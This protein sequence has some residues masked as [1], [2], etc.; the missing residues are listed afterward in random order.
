MNME[1][2]IQGNSRAGGQDTHA[3]LA[4]GILWG[5]LGGLAG[6]LLMDLL[7]MGILVLAGLPALTCFAI[8]GDTVARFFSLLGSAMVGSEAT[9]IITHYVIGPA[10]GGIFGAFIASV[11]ALRTVTLKK[12]IWLSVLYVEIL[13]QP[14]LLMSVLLLEMK[15]PVIAAWYGGAFVM[16]FLLGIIVAEVV[17]RGLKH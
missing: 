5:L 15:G 4:K 6:T 8:V 16:H 12:C 11:R 9:G 13:S 3:S 14:L 1:T 2:A 7:L 10:I 17:W